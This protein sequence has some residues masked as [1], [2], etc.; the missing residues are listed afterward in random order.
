MLIL[1]G[2]MSDIDLLFVA[3]HATVL[4]IECIKNRITFKRSNFEGLQTPNTK[5]TVAEGD[6]SKFVR[7]RSRLSLSP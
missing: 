6:G 4:T 1:K 3:I 2:S 5:N 7:L